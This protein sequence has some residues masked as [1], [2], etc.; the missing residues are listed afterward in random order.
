MINDL[1]DQGKRGAS[2]VVPALG[3]GRRGGPL[4]LSDV[5]AIAIRSQDVAAC[6]GT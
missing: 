1:N 3:C 6:L 5:G 4:T 2:V